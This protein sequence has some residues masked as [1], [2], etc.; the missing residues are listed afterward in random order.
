[1]LH[2]KDDRLILKLNI[3]LSLNL[4]SF[5]S[6]SILQPIGFKKIKFVLYKILQRPKQEDCGYMVSLHKKWS[7]PVRIST[8]NMT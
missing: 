6:L 2:Q 1:M 4:K 5:V 8:G 3:Y 7:F